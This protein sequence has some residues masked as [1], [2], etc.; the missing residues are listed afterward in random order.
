MNETSRASQPYIITTCTGTG[1]DAGEWKWLDAYIHQYRRNGGE[2]SE[3]QS[4]G[5]DLFNCL[6]RTQFRHHIKEIHDNILE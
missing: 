5:C 3:P 1:S 6:T 4:V 2:W